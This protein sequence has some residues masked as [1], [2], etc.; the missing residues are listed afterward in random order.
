MNFISKFK[1]SFC[2]TT[3]EFYWDKNVTWTTGTVRTIKEEKIDPLSSKVLKVNLITQYS[4]RPVENEESYVQIAMDNKPSL[5][6]GPG[7]VKIS[8][9]GQTYVEVFN[10]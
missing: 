5:T 9:K 2:P 8:E 10:C 3:N 6:G 4:T 1:F 7:L